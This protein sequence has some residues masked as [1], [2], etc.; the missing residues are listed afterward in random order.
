MEKTEQAGRSK[1][2][3]LVDDDPAIRSTL[4][5][6][7]VDLGFRVSTAENGR[8][9][10]DMLEQFQESIHLLITDIA[11]PVMDGITLIRHVRQRFD[12]LPI[13]VISGYAD[14]AQIAAAGI[15]DT[16][17]FNKPMDFAEIE[18]FLNRI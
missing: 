16:V 12:T 15:H 2:I 8:R 17:R 6:F 11:M 18:R 13:A 7:L 1:H 9:A 14:D 4:E 5:E 10:I 3:L